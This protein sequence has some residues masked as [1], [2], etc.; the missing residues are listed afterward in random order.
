MMNEI[1]KMAYHQAHNIHVSLNIDKELSRYVN[2]I[3]D[4]V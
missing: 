4:T 2:I 1:V 3:N